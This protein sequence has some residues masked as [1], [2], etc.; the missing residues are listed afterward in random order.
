MAYKLSWVIPLRVLLIELENEVTMG[1]MAL[2]VAETH[3]YVNAGVPQI[4]ILIDATKLLNKPIN[5]R[6]MNEIARSI[7]NPAIGWWVLINPGKMIWFAASMLSRLTNIK[8]KSARSIEEALN[9]LERVD[10]AL[11]T[12]P[13]QRQR[14]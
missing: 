10:L 8:L 2:M 14:I 13:T 1:E 7:P 9:I 6:E 4:H 11:D 5:F 12:E 3:V